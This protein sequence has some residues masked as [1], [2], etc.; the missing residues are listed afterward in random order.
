MTGTKQGSTQEEPQ[1]RFLITGAKGF[2]GAWIVKE[3]VERGDRPYVFDIDRGSARLAALLTP[4]QLA[5]VPFIQ[6]DVTQFADVESAIVEHGITHVLHLAGI[7]VPGCAAHPVRGAMVNVVGTLNV[8]EVARHRRGLVQSIVYASSAAVFGPEEAYGGNAVPEGAPLLPGT[9]YGVFKQCN[10]GNARIY[11]QNDG[12]SSVG[13]R[14]W[15]VYGVGRDQ[16]ISSGPTKAIKAAVVGRPYTIRFTG[17]VD[18]QYV[19]DTSRIFIRCAEA[20]ISG[21]KVYTPRGSVIRVQEFLATLEQILPQAHTLIKAEGK[22]LPIAADLDDSALQ[23][24]LGCVPRTPLEEGIRET[25][26][27]F[28]RLRRAGRLDTEDLEI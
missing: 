5:S 2:I 19:R 8:F 1:R 24:D 23:H 13:I 10:E 27:I 9:H 12:I 20:A 11:F 16:G 28:E 26:A 4:G 22:P 17:S 3:L 14:P 7:Q 15:A 21:A 6:G 25:A 18:L